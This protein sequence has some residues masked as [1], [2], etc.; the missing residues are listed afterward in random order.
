M[1]G[2]PQSH[3]YLFKE[4][5]SSRETKKKMKNRIFFVLESNLQLYN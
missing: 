2:S 1:H 3:A 5:Y 4:F